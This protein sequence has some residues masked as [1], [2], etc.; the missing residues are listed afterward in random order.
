MAYSFVLSFGFFHLMLLVRTI[1][2]LYI[3]TSSLALI[4]LFAAQWFGSALAAE[5]LSAE[6]GVGQYF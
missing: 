1:T 4:T 3:L 6:D 5:T 2:E